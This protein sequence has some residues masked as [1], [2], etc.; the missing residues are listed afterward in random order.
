MRHPHPLFKS[1]LIATLVFAGLFAL[2]RLPDR[3]I[4]QEA[5]G[6]IYDLESIPKRKVGLVL[7]CAP[8]L[9]FHNRLDAAIELFEAGMIEYI[10]VSGDNHAA[11]YDEASWMRDALMER[12]IPD[13]YVIRDFA[14]FSTF[15]SI[16]RA[17][18]V[19]GQQEITIISQD[20]HIR[21]ALFIAK[22]SDL[23][24]V[25]YAA[26]D[27]EHTLAAP[28]LRREA[29]A[30][31]KTILDLYIIHRKPRFL[32]EPVLIGADPLPPDSS[33]SEKA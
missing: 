26:R 22:R 30:R 12:G 32:G 18:E 16:V 5:R 10:L 2:A 20:F 17:R 27:I 9:Y 7:G 8:N 4:Y 21:R 24:A 13:E 23:D 25:G 33:A 6:R 19:F 3:W 31:V 28:T 1:L 11:G 14:G 29:L 15:D